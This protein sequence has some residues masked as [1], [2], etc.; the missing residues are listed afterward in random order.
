MTPSPLLQR[1]LN[2][3]EHTRHGAPPF[4]N[5]NEILYCSI[6]GWCVQSWVKTFLL[7]SDNHHQY[8]PLLTPKMHFGTL[9]QPS[10]P[11]TWQELF[12][13]TLLCSWVGRARP[14]LSSSARK[15]PSTFSDR[16]LQ[17]GTGSFHFGYP[18]FDFQT[19]PSISGGRRTIS[20]RREEIKIGR[21]HRTGR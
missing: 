15:L 14:I 16:N 12:L 6:C 13:S 5:C 7:S 8:V 20:H 10:I 9:F 3:E 19:V 11:E 1:G 21:A 4:M 2:E 18:L 17:K